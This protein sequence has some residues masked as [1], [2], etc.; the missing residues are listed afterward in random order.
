VASPIL[1][2]VASFDTP[3]L[4]ISVDGRLIQARQG[5]SVLAAM[6]SHGGHVR[7]HEHG[8][9][10]RGGF[11]LMGACQECWVWLGPDERGR[12]CTTPVADGMQ[13]STSAN[14]DCG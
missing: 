9:E 14:A 5:E 4:S 2:R 8:G 12:A 6:L 11:C 10:P 7:R 3:L 13:V 1:F